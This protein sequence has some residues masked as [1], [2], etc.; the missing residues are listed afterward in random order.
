V[1]I[2]PSLVGPWYT[3]VTAVLLMLLVGLRKGVLDVRDGMGR[4]PACGR[5]RRR[6]RPCSCGDRS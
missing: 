1:D 2:E 4:C 5:L 3:T 6:S